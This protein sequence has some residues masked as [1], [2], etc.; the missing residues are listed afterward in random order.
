MRCVTVGLFCEIKEFVLIVFSSYNLVTQLRVVRRSID[1]A[2]NGLEIGINIKA[3]VEQTWV[4]NI[5]R[6]QYRLGQMSE[7]GDVCVCAS[8]GQQRQQTRVRTLMCPAERHACCYFV[9]I[10]LVTRSIC[11][12]YATL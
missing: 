7:G 8:D 9:S 10:E 5:V 11:A 3:V 2:G 4:A 6:E 1:S 12:L